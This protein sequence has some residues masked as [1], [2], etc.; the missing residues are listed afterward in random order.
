M[1]DKSNK[2]S[3]QSSGRAEAAWVS[4]FVLLCVLANFWLDSHQASRQPPAPLPKPL[5]APAAEPGSPAAA[6]A[7]EPAAF[8]EDRP[9]RPDRAE[10]PSR[11]ESISPSALPYL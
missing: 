7:Q 3:P 1:I 11:D 8:G 2:P 6:S 5:A 9:S 4:L 10:R